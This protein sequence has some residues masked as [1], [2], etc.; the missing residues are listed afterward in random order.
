MLFAERDLSS[1]IFIVNILLHNLALRDNLYIIKI[2]AKTQL[3][4]RAQSLIS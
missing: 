2:S 1:D 4:M 3:W